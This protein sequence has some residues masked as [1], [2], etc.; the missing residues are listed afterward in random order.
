MRASLVK[1]PLPG[2]IS[3]LSENPDQAETLYQLLIP[4]A[5]GSAGYNGGLVLNGVWTC[6]TAR[7]PRL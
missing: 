4:E 5:Y 2:Q 1:L 6:A 7:N 3:K